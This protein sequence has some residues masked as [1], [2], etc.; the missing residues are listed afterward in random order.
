M[1][2]EAESGPI[3]GSASHEFMVACQAG[4]DIIVHTEDFTY[5]ANIEKAEVDAAA[6]DQAARSGR[7]AGPPWRKSTRPTSARI[8]AVCNFLKTQPADMIKTLIY[9]SRQFCR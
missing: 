8:E 5:A 9:S 6:G 7:P 3:G 1:I 2:V 4:E